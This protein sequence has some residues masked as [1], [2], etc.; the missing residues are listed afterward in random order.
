MN[1]RP[2]FHGQNSLSDDSQMYVALR[3]PYWMS[4]M[5]LWI[6]TPPLQRLRAVVSRHIYQSLCGVSHVELKISCARPTIWVHQQGVA[7]YGVSGL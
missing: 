3:F 1:P 7:L 5:V 4:N 2:E 6:P